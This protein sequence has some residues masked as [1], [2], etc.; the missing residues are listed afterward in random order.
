MRSSLFSINARN[1]S[2]AVELRA[3]CTTF[4]AMAYIIAV[5]PVILVSAGIPIS[6]A[7]TSTCAAAGLSTI[8]LG[9]LANRP[10][11]LAPGMGLNAIVAIS[12]T[13]AAGGDWHAAMSCVFVEGICLL[14]LVLCGFRE[15]MLTSIPDTLRAALTAGLGL[16]VALIG[17]INSHMVVA[18]PDTLVAFGNIKDPLFL[19]G[20]TA[21]ILTCILHAKNIP[22]AIIIGMLLAVLVGIPLGVTK[23]P[24]GIFSLPDF[25]A[26]AAPFQKDAEGVLGIVKMCSSP[27]LITFVFSLLMTDFFD[28]VG[29]SLAVA[30]QGHFLT[31]TGKVKNLKAIL[32]SDSVAAVF[33]GYLAASSLTVY[34]ESAAGATDG[35]R[36]GLTAI[37]CGVLFLVGT[38]ISPLVACIDAAATSGAL[39]LVGYLM[40]DQITHINWGDIVD[41]ISSFLLFIGI[42]LT[43]SISTGLGLGFISYVILSVA[44]GRAKRVKPLMWVAAAAFLVSFAIT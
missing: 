21:I 37:T 43:Y 8:F 1:S 33:G 12:I 14:V 23:P 2:I 15:A 22:G 11:A 30:K 13:E 19:V 25:S 42:P 40:M 27:A 38:F 16:F 17:L 9:L 34:L 6:A 35:G 31:K 29:S 39:V 4:L 28:T 24:E 5:N 20:A 41:G 3:G 26:F 32:I 10:L 18:N 36:T 7:I 44:L